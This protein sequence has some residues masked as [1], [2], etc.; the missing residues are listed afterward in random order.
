MKKMSRRKFLEAGALNSI[1]MIGGM[2]VKFPV[3]QP[4][5]EAPNEATTPTTLTRHERDL[6]RNAMDEII[7]AGDGMPA[8]SEV[9]SMGYLDQLTVK[10][11]Q[12]AKELHDSLRDLDALSRTRRNASFSALAHDQKVEILESLEKRNALAFVS[13]QRLVYEAYYTRPDVWK[14][15]GY[16]FYPTDSMGPPVKTVWNDAVLDKVRTKPNGYR[17]AS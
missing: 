10:Y 9:G 17:E 5:S 15:I 2:T 14:L 8:A 11:P 16:T 3:L 12:V 6:L 13:L 1:A 7:P 4:H